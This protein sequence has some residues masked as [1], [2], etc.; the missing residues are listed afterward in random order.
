MLPQHA[1]ITFDFHNTLVHCDEWFTLEIRTLVSQFLRWRADVQG[2]IV[3]SEQAAAAETAY[4]ALRLDIQ[5]H[6]N[7]QSAEE[8]IA[9][10]LPQIGETASRDEIEQGVETIMRATLNQAT[11][12]PGAPAVV[13]ALHRAGAPLGIVS[14][15]VYHPF[16]VWALERFGMLDAFQIVT[17]S[18]SAGFYKSRPEIYWSTLTQLNAEPRRSVH[19]GDSL[20]YDVDGAQRAGMRAVWFNRR[21]EQLTNGERPDLTLT[22]FDDAAPALLDFLAEGSS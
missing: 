11:P 20:R 19:I 9:T 1:A 6:G 13:Q 4:R 3:T 22:S 17:T 14:S 21:A 15:A 12:V 8:C 18:A 5:R 10:V 16:L 7:E 2:D